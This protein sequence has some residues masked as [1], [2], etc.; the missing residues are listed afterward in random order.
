MSDQSTNIYP[1]P[2]IAGSKKNLELNQYQPVDLYAPAS[3][4][5]DSNRLKVKR[6]KLHPA[7]HT[8]RNAYLEYASGGTAPQYSIQP[9]KFLPNCNAESHQ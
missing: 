1:N 9:A 4:S 2:A 6:L 3:V 5:R 8:S 7:I